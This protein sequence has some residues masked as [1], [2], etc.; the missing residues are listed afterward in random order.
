MRGSSSAGVFQVSIQ[1]ADAMGNP[2]RSEPF[3]VLKSTKVD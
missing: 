1:D 3:F 2:L